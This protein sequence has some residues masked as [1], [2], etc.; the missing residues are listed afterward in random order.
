MVKG[1]G[2]T[3]AHNEIGHG[4]HNGVQLSGNENLI[5]FNHIHHVCTE[6]GDVG[7]FYMGRDW[8]CRGNV[9]RFNHFHDTGGVGMG[10]MAVYL[11]DCASGTTIYGNVFRGCTRAAFVGG[12]RDN[13][14]ENNIFV[15]CDPAV[16]IDG[17]GL[18]PSPV[19]HNM[20]YNTMKKS[21]DL[22]LSHGSTYLDRYPEL[23]DLDRY[24]A[25]DA[26]VPPEGNSVVRN[27]SSGGNWIQIHWRAEPGMVRVED[28]LVEDD[29]GFID[30][31]GMDF[32]LR[33]DSPALE[34]GFRPIPFEKIGPRKVPGE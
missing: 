7:A 3:V 26:G 30:A 5:E 17:R 4:P 16:M 20:V 28:N 12:G 22:M 23:R 10:S 21:L 11:D 33:G 13:L 14:I 2:I 18:D 31:A 19:W 34:I 27:I 24:Y 32:G 15:D 6:T 9:V 1:V 8:T 25:G 29:P